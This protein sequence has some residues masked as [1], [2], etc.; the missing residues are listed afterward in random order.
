MCSSDLQDRQARLARVRTLLEQHM[1]G[2]DTIEIPL[3]SE[4]WRTDRL[5]R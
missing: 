2:A 4:C 5:P 3:T 1:A